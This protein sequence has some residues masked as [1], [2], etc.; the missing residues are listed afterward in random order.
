VSGVGH[1]GYYLSGVGHPNLICLTIVYRCVPVGWQLVE[2]LKGDEA[3]RKAL[4]DELLVEALS[5]KEWK[6]SALLAVAREVATRDD[7]RELRSDVNSNI[8]ELRDYID[9]S[10]R[11][12]RAYVDSR[13][14][15]LN[16]RIDVLLVTVAVTLAT[17]LIPLI[18]RLSGA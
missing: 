16:S 4:S 5:R 14:D 17:T 10:V 2:E 8:R 1:K 15:R 11:E 12:L 13:F 7:I 6:K 9:A 18:L 3:L